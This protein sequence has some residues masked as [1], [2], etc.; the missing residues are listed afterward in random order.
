M[1][2]FKS[3][4]LGSAAGL[5]AVSGASAADL[6]VK[7]PAPVEYV[8]VCSVHG[9]GF[10][11]IP[12]SDVC[13]QFS[14]RVRAEYAFR[15]ALVR[16]EDASGFRANGRLNVDVR[17]TTEYGLLRAF[18]RFDHYANSGTST[19]AAPVAGAAGGG[20]AAVNPLLDK[21]F[22]Q[23]YT[24]TAGFFTA[25]RTAS[26]FDFYANTHQIEGNVGSD[27]PNV[28]LFAYTFTFGGGFSATLAV[29]NAY[30]RRSAAIGA[31]MAV[32]LP[33]GTYHPVGGL[34]ATDLTGAAGNALAYGGQ[35]MPDV[36]ANLRVDQSW[37][38]AQ[39]SAA[40]HQMFLSNWAAPT[41][42]TAIAPNGNVAT[43]VVAGAPAVAGTPI[44]S[45]A[46]TTYGW[47]VQGGVKINLPM[48]AA[49]DN[50]FIQAAY[51]DGA[52]SYVMGGVLAG[53]NN[54]RNMVAQTD[55]YVDVFGNVKK[56]Q[57]WSVLAAFQHYFTPSLYGAIMAGY[58][59][60]E[61]S[62]L[63]ANRVVN[64]PAATLAAAPALGVWQGA[65]TG[66]NDWSALHV[67][68]RIAWFPVRNFEIGLG[69]GWTRIDPNGSVLTTV[70]D[71]AGAQ[72]GPGAAGG[73]VVKRVNHEDTFTV[74]LR[75]ERN[76]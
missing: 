4:L 45:Y 44:Q 57:S 37:G 51:G 25:G 61:Y 74:R 36:V 22:I 59:Q 76:F 26:F 52:V 69:V 10:F 50:L 17:Q 70:V 13:I 23:W 75:F 16:G 39:L 38:S 8:K 48:L 62:G 60:V 47:A 46:N 5:V 12:G 9:A 18:I 34:I 55:G 40:V 28:E 33:A 19:Y 3:L 54:G 35:R 43:A 6:G 63:G 66:F 42:V 73:A 56:S 58:G 49:G 53:A 14:G 32:G 2:L 1:K 20:A 24:G 27:A 21:A 68:G 31:G 29:E 11:Y 64:V 30:A 72:G 65:R 7:K 71:P 15:Q 67:S 41:V